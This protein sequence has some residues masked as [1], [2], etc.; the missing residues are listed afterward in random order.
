MI[1]NQILLSKKF[2]NKNY[3]FVAFLEYSTSD[4]STST[5]HFSN[6]EGIINTVQLNTPHSSVEFCNIY[7]ITSPYSFA[8]TEFG[9][10]IISL[11]NYKTNTV[12]TMTINV[13]DGYN[14]ATALKVQSIGDKLFILTGL[15]NSDLFPGGGGSSYTDYTSSFYII[16][17][18]TKTVDF[19]SLLDINLMLS[20]SFAVR[21]S[22][23]DN[24]Y[25]VVFANYSDIMLH[26]FTCSSYSGI[27]VPITNLPIPDITEISSFIYDP[28]SNCIVCCGYNRDGSIRI[29]ISSSP[30]TLWEYKLTT[31]RYYNAS[32]VQIGYDNSTKALFVSV[33]ND[34][35][36][37]L[38]YYGKVS[39][40]IEDSWNLS[41]F[42]YDPYNTDIYP[43]SFSLLNDSILFAYAL[44]KRI[45]NLYTIDF[46]SMKLTST[47]TD[48]P[49]PI[50]SNKRFIRICVNK[51]FYTGM[52]N[53]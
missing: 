22:T 26:A 35:L 46:D 42:I 47:I 14:I 34:V 50:E 39:S 4:P 8:F 19:S 45:L 24:L 16:D 27:T 37:T 10:N 25:D 7:S 29:Y 1:T 41:F 33:S 48:F 32:T 31:P 12:D 20:F 5:I 6:N 13:P 52:S 36:E 43:S 38:V 2:S 40:F 53:E 49:V 11:Y 51:N 30:N 17:L 3:P 18:N 21:S 15:L 44:Y 9:S 23:E 28:E